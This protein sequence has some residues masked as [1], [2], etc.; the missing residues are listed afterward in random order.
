MVHLFNYRSQMMSKCD[1]IKKVAQEMQL[2][3]SLMSLLHFDIICDLL[4]TYG[5]MECIY[6]VSSKTKMFSRV[7]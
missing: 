1:E 4:Q 5:N 2:G 7:T 3:V 6:F